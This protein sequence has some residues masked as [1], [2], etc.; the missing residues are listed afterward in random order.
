MY[1]KK[2]PSLFFTLKQ[3]HTF[4]K[5]P[6]LKL[7]CLLQNHWIYD[8]DIRNPKTLTHDCP[9]LL[10]NP[11]LLSELLICSLILL[12]LNTR[13]TFSNFP[14]TLLFRR[15]SILEMSR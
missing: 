14:P 9:Y 11:I 10:V 4:I 2:I 1:L 12:F 13:V 5:D 7:N 6:Q 3:K 15:V 8:S